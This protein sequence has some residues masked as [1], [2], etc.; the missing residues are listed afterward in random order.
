MSLFSIA[1]FFCLCMYWDRTLE[2]V[3]AVSKSVLCVVKWLVNQS[4]ATAVNHVVNVL[5][6]LSDEG[7]SAQ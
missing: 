2:V 6:L 4:V 1:V 7:D 5:Q 3:I